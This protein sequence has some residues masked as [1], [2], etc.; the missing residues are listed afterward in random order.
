MQIGAVILAA[1]ASTRMKRVKQTLLFRG[2]TLVDNAIQQATQA[3]FT[4]VVVV[5][6]AHAG[7]VR[8][9]VAITSA[10]IVLNQEWQ[11]GMGSSISVGVRKIL[12]L[13]P[14]LDTLAVLLADQPLVTS[15]HLKE[16]RSLFQLQAVSIVAARYAGTLGVPALF[17]RS[18]V[19]KLLTLSPEAGARALLREGGAEL[20][21]YDL[22]EAACDIDTPDDFAAL[23]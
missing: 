12:E 21:P 8:Q 15:D 1:G 19:T 11:R 6:G 5:L 22:P 2:R 17:N 4:P 18:Q 13:A 3:G 16:M 23:L 7:A 10:E 14:E 9:A 20:Q